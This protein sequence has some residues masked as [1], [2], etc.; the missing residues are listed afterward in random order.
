[1]GS[2][3]KL[4]NDAITHHLEGDLA[5]AE[6]LYRRILE[7]DPLQPQ[8]LSML[9]MILMSGLR[10]AEAEAL[11]V[12]HLSM[13]P[14]DSMSLLNLGRL[15]QIRGEDNEAVSLFHQA[16]SGMPALA[17]IYNDLAVSLH[18]LGKCHEALAALDHALSIDPAFGVAHDNRGIVL[19]DCDRF[20]E[21][22]AAYQ[23]A[24]SCTPIQAVPERVAILLNLARAAYEAKEFETVEKA[25][26]TILDMEPNNV[27]GNEYL[28]KAL[29]RTRRNGEA[30]AMLNRRTRA[31]GLVRVQRTMHPEATILVLGGVG[32]S[33]VPTSDLFDPSLFATMALTL[34]SPDQP[35]APFGGISLE[36]LSGADLVFNTLG[37]VEQNGGQIESVKNLLEF[38]GKPTLNPPELVAPTG[39]NQSK[40]LF[41][42]IRG[43]L[44]PEVSWLMRNERI[45]F[46]FVAQPFLVRPAGVHGGEDLALIATAS[47]WRNYLVKVPHD[48]FIRMAFHDFRDSRGC[49]RKYRFIFID[50]KPYPYHLAIADDWLVHYWR[51]H[52]NQS[53]WKK[54]E[55]ERFVADWRAVFGSRAASAVEQVAQRLDLDYGGM[56]CSILANGEVLF[57]EANASMLVYL[58]E[59]KSGFPNKYEAGLRIRE[60]VTDMVRNR[61]SRHG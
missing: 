4:L 7:I 42:D 31:R 19:Y 25:C 61:I 35:D 6:A 34:V 10:N 50:R 32:A 47:D 23:R 52:M 48:R 39:R 51:S 1:M 14:G 2:M 20:M 57:F 60:A 38:L 18:R 27:D 29:Y 11:F 59:Q 49:Y 56:D 58:E 26:C 17:P 9:G 41:G 22:V 43:L 40:G 54:R 5:C 13:E 12:R 44:V 3:K 30:V 53:D 21:A 37:E 24:L 36:E 8:A 16:C 45:D 55:E 15:L 28:A 46:N 33:H